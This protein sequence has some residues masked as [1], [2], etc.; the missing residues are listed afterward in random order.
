MSE[1]RAGTLGGQESLACS[2]GILTITAVVTAI[3]DDS[4]HSTERLQRA[5]TEPSLDGRTCSSSH[6]GQVPQ[7]RPPPQPGV[8]PK[9]G[10]LTVEFSGVATGEGGSASS[11]LPLPGLG[12]L[13]G[14]PRPSH[15]GDFQTPWYPGWCR[16]PVQLGA[17]GGQDLI[18]QRRSEKR[19]RPSATEA[20]GPPCTASVLRSWMP[21]W[22]PAEPGWWV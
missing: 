14:S 17:L 5:K 9:V 12:P 13:K 16:C 7:V 22:S 6:T 2:G 4:K 10:V 3:T 15:T 19:E 1:G 8:P 20:L 18:P 21:A 11:H